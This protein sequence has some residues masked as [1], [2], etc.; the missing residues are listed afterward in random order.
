MMSHDLEEFESA[1]KSRCGHYWEFKPSKKIQSLVT[2]LKFSHLELEKL[3]RPPLYIA[4]KNGFLQS[5][6]IFNSN[7]QR[8]F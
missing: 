5:G 8:I 7:Y 3:L 4:H 2:Y 6:S 1:L